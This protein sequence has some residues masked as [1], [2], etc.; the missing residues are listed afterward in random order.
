MVAM[1]YFPFL[2]YKVLT[3]YPYLIF[4]DEI[5]TIPDKYLVQLDKFSFE[6]YSR[7]AKTASDVEIYRVQDKDTVMLLDFNPAG[8]CG[9]YIFENVSSPRDF[10]YDPFQHNY[11]DNDH[12]YMYKACP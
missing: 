3:T 10:Q 7:P 11:S 1:T 2:K 9:V 5:N 4:I 12:I 6:F 8:G